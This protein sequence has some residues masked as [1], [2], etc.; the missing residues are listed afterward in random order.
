[1]CVCVHKRERDMLLHSFTEGILGAKSTTRN[2]N[3]RSLVDEWVHF[4]MEKLK[5]QLF[6]MT[7]LLFP[8]SVSCCGSLTLSVCLGGP[9]CT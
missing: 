5:K 4:V 6:V 9:K 7:S 3:N 2:D 1:M 8:S